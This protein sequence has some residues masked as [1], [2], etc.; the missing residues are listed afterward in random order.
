MAYEVI[1]I[2]ATGHYPMVEK[3]EE[4]NRLLR[5]VLAAMGAN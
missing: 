1:D 5:Q 3:P 4:F 2:H